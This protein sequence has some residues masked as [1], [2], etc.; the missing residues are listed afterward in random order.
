M[1]SW[2]KQIYE[3]TSQSTARINKKVDAL[4]ASIAWKDA[5]TISKRSWVGGE[6]KRQDEIQMTVS[7]SEMRN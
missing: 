5:K 7:G 1:A 4:A 2:T 3:A 6:L